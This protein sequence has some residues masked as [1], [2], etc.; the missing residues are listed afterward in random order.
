M[1]LCT[2]MYPL[3]TGK[4]DGIVLANT[5]KASGNTLGVKMLPMD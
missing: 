3:D 1:G 2:H 5:H 4:S